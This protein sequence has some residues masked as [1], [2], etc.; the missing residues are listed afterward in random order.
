MPI[1]DNISR[2]RRELNSQQIQEQE[3]VVEESEYIP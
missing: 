1:L 3:N 2:H